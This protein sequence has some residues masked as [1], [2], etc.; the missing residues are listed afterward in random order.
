MFL[1]DEEKTIR[2]SQPAQPSLIK[3]EFLPKLA[4]KAHA[5]GSSL[6]AYL[7]DLVPDDRGRS[8]FLSLE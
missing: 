6:F 4:K 8:R 2:K 3:T 7:A 1:S 5:K